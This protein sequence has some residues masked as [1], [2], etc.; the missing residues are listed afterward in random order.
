METQVHPTAEVSPKAKIGPKTRIWHHT[1]VRE[2]AEIGENC[3]IGKNVY[4]DYGVKIGSNVKI[5]NNA[6]V[7]HGVTIEDGV[8]VGPGVCFTNDLYP[9]A[10]IWSKQRLVKT[11]VKE[12]ASIGANSTIV[13]G[14]TIGEHAMIGAGSVITKDVPAH[15]LAYGIPAKVHGFVCPC[16]AKLKKKGKTFLCPECKK[17]VNIRK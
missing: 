7:Y 13:C 16:G 10:R 3:V 4:I 17:E 11:L 8:F 14:N 15:A 1:H 6:S 2:D 12:G 5:Q 9:R